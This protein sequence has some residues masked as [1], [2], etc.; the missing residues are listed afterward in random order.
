MANIRVSTMK[1]QFVENVDSETLTKRLEVL[2]ILLSGIE[3]RMTGLTKSENVYQQII[4]STVN[5]G[6]QNSKFE[7]EPDGSETRKET[8][9]LS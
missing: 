9:T 2:R 6:N 5:A 8:K 1:T 4:P 3:A 7:Q